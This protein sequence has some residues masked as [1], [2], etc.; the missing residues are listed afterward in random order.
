MGSLA[1]GSL[2]ISQFEVLEFDKEINP[3]F[4]TFVDESVSKAVFRDIDE[5]Y[6]EFSVGWV[7]VLDMFDADSLGRLCGVG[8]NHI[9]LRMRVDERRVAGAALKKFVAKEE[10]RVKKEKEIPRL[11]RQLRL[12]IKERVTAQLTRKALPV[13]KCADVAW[14]VETGVVYLLSTSQDMVNVFED[15]FR[16]TF[17]FSVRQ[18]VPYTVA[19]HLLEDADTLEKLQ[20]TIIN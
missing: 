8:D 17:G 18:R 2:S 10:R 3:N 7:S 11:P 6:E 20:P 13:P 14:N 16:E 19:T 4:W 15:L 9:A 1:S 5:T 12:E